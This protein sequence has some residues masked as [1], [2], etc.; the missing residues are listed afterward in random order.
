MSRN[1]FLVSP[2]PRHL[3]SQSKQLHFLLL[4]GGVFSWLVLIWRWGPGVSWCLAHQQRSFLIAVYRNS[5][6]VTASPVWLSLGPGTDSWSSSQTGSGDMDWLADCAT[7]NQGRELRLLCPIHSWPRCGVGK[8]GES[9]RSVL[10][11]VFIVTITVTIH[12]LICMYL[13]GLCRKHLG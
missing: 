8:M 3:Y 2:P 4:N 10:L 7:W 12:F 5:G 11:A 13:S 9:K 1:I 6:C